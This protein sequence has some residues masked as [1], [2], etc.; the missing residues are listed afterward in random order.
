MKETSTIVISPPDIEIYKN[1]RIVSKD[2][3]KGIYDMRSGKMLLDYKFDYINFN[4]IDKYQ[5][6]IFKKEAKWA[7]CSVSD[8]ENYASI[9][10]TI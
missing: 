9:M 1:F 4:Y 6:I 5:F 7:I 10:C 3:K 8:L 2:K